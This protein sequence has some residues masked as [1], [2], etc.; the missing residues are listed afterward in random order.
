MMG[1][2]I[3]S[4]AWTEYQYLIPDDWVM[5]GVNIPSDFGLNIYA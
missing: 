5:T 1:V 3:P 4:I 2:R